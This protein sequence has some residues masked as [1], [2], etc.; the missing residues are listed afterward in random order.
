MDY[1]EIRKQHIK[2]VLKHLLDNWLD[3]FFV[4]VLLIFLII[5]AFV[6]FNKMIT[7]TEIQKRLLTIVL[8]A[9]W[10]VIPIFYNEV[11]NGRR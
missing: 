11:K 2:P 3:I 8:T 4:I 5:T 1:K 10:L 6:G 9:I 7:A